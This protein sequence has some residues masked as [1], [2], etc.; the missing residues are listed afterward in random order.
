MFLITRN[1]NLF[2]NEHFRTIFDVMQDIYL[3]SVLIAGFHFFH[4][5]EKHFYH[6][7]ARVGILK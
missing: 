7:K 6:L 5:L 1:C 2:H 4:S 3:D